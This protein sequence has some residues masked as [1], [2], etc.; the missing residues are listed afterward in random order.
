MSG[1][2]VADK[3]ALDSLRVSSPGLIETLGN[4]LALGQTPDQIMNHVRSRHKSQFITSL[5]EGA[6]HEL[7][8]ESQRRADLD[9]FGLKGE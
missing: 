8:R 9:R 1:D 5:V 2:E 3:I 4:L 6:T 7:A